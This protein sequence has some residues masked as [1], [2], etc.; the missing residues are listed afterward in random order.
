ESPSNSSKTN[1]SINAEET[2]HDVEMDARESVEDDM[3]DTKIVH[4]ANDSVPKSDSLKWFKEDAMD[5]P[6]TPDPEWQKEPN[7]AP[8]QSWLI[9]LVNAQKDPLSFKDVMGF[10]FDFTNFIK[11]CL[12]K[13]KLTKVNFEG[14]AF[15]LMKGKHRNYIE[16]EYNFEQCY[17][18]LTDQLD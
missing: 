16:L 5:R 9:D 6:K 15:K 12:K 10:V 7:D 14:P 3:V 8:K 13:D 1:K 4:Q 17:L 2:V 18:A 11:N